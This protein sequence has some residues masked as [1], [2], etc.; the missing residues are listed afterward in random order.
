L[1]ADLHFQPIKQEAWYLQIKEK[2]PNSK[3]PI[4]KMSIAEIRKM[5]QENNFVCDTCGNKFERNNFTLEEHI[6]HLINP[7]VLWSCEDCIMKDLKQ[8]NIV[9]A[10][11]EPEPN[12]WQSENV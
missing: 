2:I 4:D 1:T 6:T 7:I 3:R 10:T 9:G 12:Q 11:E 5:Y 8:G